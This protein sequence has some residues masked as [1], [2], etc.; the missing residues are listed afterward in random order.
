[1]IL[2]F[3]MMIKKINP[4]S[5]Y[6]EHRDWFDNANGNAKEICADIIAAAGYVFYAEKFRQEPNRSTARV[7][8]FY[9]LKIDKDLALRFEIL[10]N[11]VLDMPL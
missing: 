2:F 3:L 8:M 6:I 5:R 9:L 4:L 11:E 10:V 1:M 7:T